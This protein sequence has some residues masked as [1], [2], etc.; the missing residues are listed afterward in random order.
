M[1]DFPI[2]FS[3]GFRHVTD[4][5]RVEYILFLFAISAIFLLKDW[6]RVLVLVGFFTLGYSLSY[7][8]SAF[9]IVRPDIRLIDFLVFLTVFLTAFSNILRKKERFHIRGGVQRNF[10]LALLF[11]IVHGFGFSNYISGILDSPPPPFLSLLFFQIGL[12]VGILLIIFLFLMIAF[13][14]ISIFGIN[15]RDWVL[16]VSSAIAGVA[17]TMMFESKYW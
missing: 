8:L 6:R 2:Y 11:G 10:F 13:L 16:V 9:G 12:E 1:N 7:Y 14:F 3:L 15:R 5:Y 17:I 4:I